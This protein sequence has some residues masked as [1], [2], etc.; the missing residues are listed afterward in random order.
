M[1]IKIIHN[2]YSAR[3]T[4]RERK[5]EMIEVLNQAGLH[6]D[7]DTTEGPG[8][9]VELAAQAV[10]DGYPTILAAGGDGTLGEVVNGIIKGAGE[11]PLPNFGIIPLGT[12][13]D[14]VY[15]LKLPNDLPGMVSL[16]AKGYTRRIDVCKVNDRYFVNNA[17]IGLEPYI[18]VQSQKIQRLK[19]EIRYMAATL[20]GIAHNPKWEMDIEW[21]TGEYHGPTTLVSIGNGARTGGFFMAPHANLFDGVMTFSFGYF[22]GRIEK[23]R[24]LPMALQEEEGNLSEHPKTHEIDTSWIKIKSTPSPTHTDGEIFDYAATEFEYSI[25]PAKLPV[26]MSPDAAS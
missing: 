7:L 11:N 26:L 5:G 10:R 24:V 1:T 15:N 4:S 2:P 8:H 9:A 21:E 19:G 25:L 23:L 13:N 16:I 17:G 18:T 20:I 3:W 14:L 6:F 12:A 22:P